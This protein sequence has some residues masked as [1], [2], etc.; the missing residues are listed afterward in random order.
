MS[1]LSPGHTMPASLEASAKLPAFLRDVD[2]RM[3]AIPNSLASPNARGVLWQAARGQF[4]LYAPGVAHY[5]VEHG[6]S[7]TIDPE[8]GASE[9]D[10]VR[11]LRMTPLA[12]LLY[13]RNMLAF[14]A[15]AAVKDGR[16]ILL[17]G[18]STAGKSTVL[19]ALIEQGWKMLADELAAVDTDDQGN[20]RVFPTFP[21]VR[22]RQCSGMKPE[23]GRDMPSSFAR[24]DGRGWQTVTQ[25]QAFDDQPRRLY[26]IFWLGVQNRD[27]IDR[28]VLAGGERFRAVGALA[29]NSHIADALFDRGEYM[30]C[31]GRLAQT[32]PVYRL[33]RPR[34]K[35]T[36]EQVVDEIE[37]IPGTSGGVLCESDVPTVLYEG[38]PHTRA[39]ACLTQP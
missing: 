30:R 36:V 11:F 5:L 33:R 9:C 32:V 4:L 37:A 25:R 20:A 3:A 12:A 26:S 39:E 13:E 10:M 8:P 38:F 6:R 31:A 34:G 1:A 18:D 21:E 15:A 35:G 27:R 19:M 2:V 23:C 14:H 16:G 22:F 24:K 17:A 29:Y 7:I 28:Q